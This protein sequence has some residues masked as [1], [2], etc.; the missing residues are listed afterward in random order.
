MLRLEEWMDIKALFNAGYSQRAI[1]ELTGRSRNTVSRMLKQ[2]T[3]TPPKP[4]ARRSL[5]DPFKPYVEARYVECRLSAVR[6]LTEIQAQGYI[7]SVVTLR[8]FVHT[9]RAPTGAQKRLTVRFETAPGEQAQVDW[10]YCGRFPQAAGQPVSIYAFVMV[11][12][13]S[14]MLYVEFTQA[15]ALPTLL[16]C[17]QH[18]FEFFGGWTRTILYD[19]MKQVRLSQQQWNLLFLDFIN[20]YGITPRTHAVRRPRTKGKVERMVHYLKDNFL[21][22]RAFDS[23]DD[24]AAQTR[25]WLDSTANARM[26][27]TTGQRPC[28]LLAREALTSFT[29]APPY[30]L[31]PRAERKVDAESF[32]R[33]DRSRYSVPP[34]YVGQSVTVEQ[35]EQRIVIRS[36]DLVIA[37]HEHAPRPGACMV[38][39]EHL[40]ALWRLALC[41]PAPP[42]RPSWQL[43]LQDG[44]ATTPLSSY[45]EV[46]G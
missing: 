42:P 23:L 39:T 43:L 1:A 27:A 32:V 9:L 17:H 46:A 12:S 22:G 18:A 16:R 25:L 11:L 24:S 8:R 2:K 29:S 37:E 14:R 28:D 6:L 31:Y 21:N 30:H 44:V 35:R 3:P 15:M 26:H 45:E 41:R 36:R 5:L 10:G 13:F 40:E 19:N 34:E 4:R 20:H 33:L 38:Q 7:G